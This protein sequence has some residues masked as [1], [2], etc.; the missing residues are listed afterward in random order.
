MPRDRNR[1]NA[2]KRQICRERER[3]TLGEGLSREKCQ[4]RHVKRKRRQNKE[5][6]KERDLKGR[7]AKRK[8]SRGRAVQRMKHQ[9]REPSKE[10]DETDTLTERDVKGKPGQE[11]VVPRKASAE[12]AVKRKR[13]Q[14]KEISGD[15]K[16]AACRSNLSASSS[17]DIFFSFHPFLLASLALDF[18]CRGIFFSLYL[19]FPSLLFSSL[20]I[21]S[22]VRSTLLM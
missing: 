22:H 14:G 9:G 12:Q 16:H 11:N 1:R 8:L 19:P 2:G 6:S 5:P 20:L 3:E 10:Q 15:V 21:S 13:C 4:E 7:V 17:S 18:F